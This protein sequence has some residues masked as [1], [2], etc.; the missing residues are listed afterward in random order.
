MKKFSGIWTAIYT[1]ALLAFTLYAV[2][3]TFV[4]ASVYQENAG[5]MNLSAFESEAG[6]VSDT[7][8]REGTEKAAQGASTEE[9]GDMD[10]TGPAPRRYQ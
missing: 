4:I 3:D 1:T 10:K 9:E 2:L 7:E 5:A 6:V 8:N